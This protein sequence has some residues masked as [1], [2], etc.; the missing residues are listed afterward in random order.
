[1]NNTQKL[2]ERIKVIWRLSAG[3]SLITGL[4]VSAL[5]L[6]PHWLWN[7]P[8]W[9]AYVGLGLTAVYVLGELIL[10]P[11]RYA[12][13]GYRI[14][15]TAVEL[16]S[17]FLFKKHIAIPIARIQNVTLEAGP[18]MQWQKL[19]QVVIATAA[20]EHDIEGVEPAVAAQLRDRIMRR[21]I[22]V[23]HDEF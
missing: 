6:L 1:M 11:Y 18:L 17:G 5:L 23:Q 4:V 10:V 21:A 12:F 13:S 8:Q 9:F 7:L 16:S 20:T 22:E 14:T 19:E 3:G 2:P 15:D